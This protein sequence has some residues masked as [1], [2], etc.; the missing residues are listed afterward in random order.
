M[1]PTMLIT[2]GSTREHID[3]VRYITNA[4]SGYQGM[5]LAYHA[6][7]RGYK[8][9]L[10][11]GQ[12]SIEIKQLRNLKIVN[13][14]SAEDMY[15]AAVKYF[16]ESQVAV[17]AAAVG[18]YR[19]K[20]IATDK[21]K[22]TGDSIMLELVPNKDIAKELGH[23][24]RDDQM[25]IGFALETSNGFDNAMKKIEKK[26]LDYVVLNVITPENKAF[27]EP[28]N[29]VSIIK[30]DGTV[31]GEVENGGKGL[32]ADKIMDQCKVYE[33]A[34]STEPWYTY[35]VE[36][37]DGT[38]YTGITNN[39]D[40]RMAQ[41]NAGIGAKYTRGRTPV[42]LVRSEMYGS[43][44]DAMKREYAIKQLPREKKEE[45]IKYGGLLLNK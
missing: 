36:C 45:I 4:S 13:V 33:K 34:K 30:K 31:V 41:H 10:I 18:D 12:T 1:K 27:N 24:K 43:K 22:R 5:M 28:T 2:A 29:T 16:P 25:V 14:V 21:I 42:K 17:C 11:V 39:L 15:Q 3:P 40:R 38:Y 32:I 7:A 23:M 26:N 19:V 6:I 20:D 37:V 8:V 9:I 44:S 35:I